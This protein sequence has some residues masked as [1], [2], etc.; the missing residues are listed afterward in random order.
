MATLKV[1]VTAINISGWQF[2]LKLNHLINAEIQMLKAELKCA[3]MEAKMRNKSMEMVKTI[4]L[5]IK[6]K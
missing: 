1:T 4:F 5:Y 2:R 6:K 3:K